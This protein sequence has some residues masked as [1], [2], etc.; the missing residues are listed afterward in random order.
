MILI[1]W[2][3]QVGVEVLVAVIEQNTVYCYC[4]Q[5]QEMECVQSLEV[6]D[7]LIADVH[8]AT[9]ICVQS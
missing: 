1:Y 8:T 2:Y 7:E 3:L 9:E 5:G 4:V 6:P